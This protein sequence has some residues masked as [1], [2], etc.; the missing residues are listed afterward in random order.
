MASI[1]LQINQ[2]DGMGVDTR[3]ADTFAKALFGDPD[4]AAKIALAKAHIAAQGA[5][6]TKLGADTGLVA[7]KTRE[8]KM[9]DD[10][11]AAA[12]GAA[13]DAYAAQVPQPVPVEA[14]R[15]DPG[16][17]GDYGPQPAIVRPQDQAI[18]DAQVKAARAMGP[19]IV[20]SP[21]NPA[22]VAQGFSRGLGTFGVSGATD[23]NKARVAGGLA[24]DAQPTTT[25]VA[26]AGDNAGVDAGARKDIEV[27]IAKA[28]LPTVKDVPG[29][30]LVSVQGTTATPIAGAEAPVFGATDKGLQQTVYTTLKAKLD[31]GQP[32]N[33]LEKAQFETAA[34]AV[35]KDNAVP[36]I[37]GKKGETLYTRDPNDPNKLIPMSGQVA[38]SQEP[39]AF[40]DQTSVE[41]ISAKVVSNTSVKMQDAGFKPSPQE[42]IDYATAY[43]HLYG[44]KQNYEK[45]AQGAI[46][47]VTTNPEP[48]SGVLTPNEVFQRAGI[49]VAPSAPAPL[50]PPAAPLAGAPPAAAPSGA[51]GG[52]NPR[53]TTIIGAAPK[54]PTQEQA[55]LQQYAPLLVNSTLRLD[56]LKPQDVPGPLIQQIMGTQGNDPN[57]VQ[58]WLASNFTT[59]EQQKFGQAVAQ[60]NQS[61]LYMLSGKAITDD[62][63]KRALMS[64]IPQPGNDQALL[65]WKAEQ[66]HAII[67]SAVRLG[68]ANDPNA[69]RTVANS[70]K[71][72]HGIDLSK[73]DLTGSL[74]PD[75]GAAPPATPRRRVYDSSGNLQ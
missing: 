46:N 24:V 63:Y 59:P 27:E 62:E 67:A 56:S 33:E 45:D 29:K 50:A 61:L 18:Y 70:I 19:L 72:Q 35:A 48:P 71:Q 53:V 14:P 30:G 49:K 15:P 57:I 60:Y 38:A 8:Q 3:L 39:G 55:Q 9:R 2:P 36:P 5:Y 26:T 37:S 43:N 32:L 68:W 75:G 73:L 47:L 7:E 41:G 52:G 1:G 23:P 65:D 31:S 20:T 25:T 22:Q 34:A 13:G 4:M 6:T 69:M 44:P 16:T 28:G 17:F 51:E 54:P 12:A 42:A 10:A 40:G 21:G 64:Y 58:R 74:A 66:R 11:A